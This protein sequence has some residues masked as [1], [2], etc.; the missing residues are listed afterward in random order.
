MCAFGAAITVDH[1]LFVTGILGTTGVIFG[2]AEA[3]IGI[4]G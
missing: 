1:R 3:V 2:K 4:M